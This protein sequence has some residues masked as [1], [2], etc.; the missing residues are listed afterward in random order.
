M[1]SDWLTTMLP[2]W[3]TTWRRARK[4]RRNI[5]ELENEYRPVVEKAER[6]RDGKVLL[7]TGRRQAHRLLRRRP[8]EYSVRSS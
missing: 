1:L 4:L 5:Y 7:E 3:F 8:K 6:E 2:K